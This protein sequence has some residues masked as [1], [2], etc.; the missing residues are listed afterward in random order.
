MELF[1]VNRGLTYV[2]NPYAE[3]NKFLHMPVENN[4]LPLY[5]NSKDKLPK[6]IWDGHENYIKCY[7]VS[8]THLQMRRGAAFFGKQRKKARFLPRRRLLHI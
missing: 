7:A 1:K 2:Y 3:E 4:P 5:E 6:P 8:Y